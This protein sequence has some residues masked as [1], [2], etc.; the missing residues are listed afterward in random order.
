[1]KRYALYNSLACNNRGKELAM[2]LKEFY[3]DDE[4]IFQDV[5]EIE[6]YPAFVS[7]IDKEVPIVVCGGDGT[8][9][10]FANQTKGIRDGREIYFFSCGTGNDFMR[11]VA[12]D[13]EKIVRVDGYLKDLPVAYVNG[14]E[15]EFINGIGY[16]IDGYCCEVGDKMREEK[17]GQ[18]IDY[19]GIA[20][21]GLLFH[22]KP[23]GA[24]ITV[25]GET[26]RFEKVWLAPTMYG[27]FYGGGM[28][29]CPEQTRDGEEK[30]VSSMLF[31]GSGKIK[32]LVIFPNLFKGKHVKFDKH[33]RVFSGK[34]ITVK[35]DEPRPLQVD[36]E[37]VL[38]V[39]EYTVKI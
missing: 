34:E 1:M 7:A 28:L 35:F 23:T 16:G 12:K 30:K 4:I 39:T 22:Y 29:P 17:P 31:F 15:Y 6:D 20:I 37:T 33:I 32:T 38:D 5:I 10:R 2:G 3:P 9:N 25:D 8:L 27:R 11:D 19:T 21:K 26:Q 13:G 24:T 36:G 14:K 18:K